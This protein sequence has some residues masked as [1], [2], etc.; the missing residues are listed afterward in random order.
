[1]AYRAFILIGG[2][3]SG[4]GTQGKVLGSV[5]NFLHFSSGDMF[6]GIDRESEVGK[7]VTGYMDRGELIPDDTTIELFTH[8]LEGLVSKGTLNPET[9][10]LVLDGIPRN[11]NQAKILSESI[12]LLGVIQIDIGDDEVLFERMR[13]RA[14]KENRPDD[15]NPDV[16]RRRIEV[17]KGEVA[18]LLSAYDKEKIHRI[19][20][21]Q[22]PIR[23]LYDIITEVLKATG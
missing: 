8:Y 14:L 10:V 3:G 5:L 19:E 2:P 13:G 11:L 15:A 21:N 17:F 6:R 1:M 7:K 16:V 23:V 22:Q 9:D 18:T 4:K 20:G 12:D